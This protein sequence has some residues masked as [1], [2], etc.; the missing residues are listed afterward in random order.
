MQCINIKH[1]LMKSEVVWGKH[2]P[3]S[4]HILHDKFFAE[5]KGFKAL[6]RFTWDHFFHTETKKI[7]GQ[8]ME[9]GREKEGEKNGKYNLYF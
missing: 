4:R 3:Q 1:E 5:K 2:S 8:I 7:K 6:S 9:R